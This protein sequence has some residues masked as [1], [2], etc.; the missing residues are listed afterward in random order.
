[1]GDPVKGGSAD[2]AVQ[3]LRTLFEAETVVGLSDGELLDHFVSRRAGGSLDALVLRHGSMV[4]NVCRRVLRDH[5]DA[6][7]A[8]QATFLVLARRAASI[9][10]RDKVGNWLYGV[11][12]QT[13]RKARALRAKK[14]LREAA[15]AAEPEAQSPPPRNELAELLD[16]ELNRLPDKYRTPIVLCEL[17]GKSHG[18]AA[19]QLGWPI[20]TVSGR[21][22]RARA[23]LAKRLARQ[24]ALATSASVAALLTQ[25]QATAKL[26]A[27]LLASTVQSANQ[28]ATGS[29]AGIVSAEVAALT[30][31]VLRSMYFS[32]LKTSTAI[33]LA[34]LLAFTLAGAGIWQARTLA[35]GKDSVA[36]KF[37]VTVNEVIHDDSTLVA[38]V[39]I[40][41]PPG[42][43]IQ[44]LSDRGKDD[45]FSTSLTPAVSDSKEP[46][47]RA[48]TRLT[49][50]ADQIEYQEG[51][52]NAYK[53]MFAYKL[54][55]ISSITSDAGPMPAGAKR[56]SDLLT[57]HMKSGEYRYGQAT[58]LVTFKGKTYS[59]VVTAAK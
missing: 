2:A 39:D 32:K 30:R 25:D 51:S 6:E 46:E 12:Y 18:E 8:F 24:S 10:P 4:W 16:Q 42:A 22:S 48:Q 45:S 44:L 21:L 26:P 38:Q 28:F 56:L 59:I 20:G 36:E 58:K 54:G 5:H 23:I 11:A 57:L 55:K 14:R 49:V 19:E 52:I 40:A 33:A 53:F 34:A 37:R 9:R 1:M 3:Y 41:T 27:T 13:A 43:T 15:E 50:L 31:E 17:E 29:A 35:G 47:G 7:D